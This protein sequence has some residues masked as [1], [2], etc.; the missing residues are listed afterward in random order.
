MLY[1]GHYE[2]DKLKGFFIA[3]YR[4]RAAEQAKTDIRAT[5]SPTPWPTFN[6]PP[7]EWRELDEVARYVGIAPERVR[8]LFGVLAMVSTPAKPEPPRSEFQQRNGL[9]ADGTV[10]MQPSTRE[11]IATIRAGLIVVDDGSESAERAL[12]ELEKR[13]GGE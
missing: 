5:E 3:G 1:R 2:H 12:T 10:R 7:V 9:N 8:A 13:I 4:A 6:R 11:L